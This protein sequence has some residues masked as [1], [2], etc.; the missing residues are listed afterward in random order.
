MGFAEWIPAAERWNSAARTPKAGSS[1]EIP[2]SAHPRWTG[3]QGNGV[4]GTTATW[5]PRPGRLDSGAGRGGW[6]GLGAGARR[7]RH[8]GPPKRSAPRAARRQPIPERRLWRATVFVLPS[9]AVH[10]AHARWARSAARHPMGAAQRVHQRAV[11]AGKPETSGARGLSTSSK[12]PP[13]Y[14]GNTCRKDVAA[15]GIVPLGAPRARWRTGDRV[16]G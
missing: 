8:R 13:R 1:V 2:C 10:E 7:H 14:C 4:G 12:P 16:L 6:G 9:H 15:S 5:P 3:Q 11:L